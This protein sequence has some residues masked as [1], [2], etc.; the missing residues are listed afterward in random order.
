MD[1]ILTC[2]KIIIHGECV[3]NGSSVDV[4]NLALR[5]VKIA[6]DKSIEKNSCDGYLQEFEWMYRYSSWDMIVKELLERSHFW[7]KLDLESALLMDFLDLK[8]QYTKNQSHGEL[9]KVQI[10]RQE[11]RWVLLCVNHW[12][13]KKSKQKHRNENETK[14]NERSIIKRSIISNSS[15]YVSKCVVMVVH[16]FC[17]PPFSSS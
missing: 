2:W 15:V 4:V 7:W 17:L 8:W 11:M 9:K 16:C 12:M 10:H 6:H 5:I 1:I 14:Q 13:R 3:K